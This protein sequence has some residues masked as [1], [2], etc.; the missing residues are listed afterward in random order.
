LHEVDRIDAHL[1]QAKA[2]NASGFLIT[3][4]RG[5]GKTSLLLHARAAAEGRVRVRDE[6]RRLNF[7]VLQTD[8]EPQTTQMAL[9][10]KIELALRRALIMNERAL[11]VLQRTWEFLQRLQAAGYGLKPKES[12]SLPDETLMEELAYSLASTTTAMTTPR[13][14]ADWGLVGVYDGVVLLVDEADSAS[15]QLE[16]GTFLKLLV[17]RVQRHGCERL[18]VGLAGTPR[19]REALLSSHESALRL[20]EVLEL[21]PL[22]RDETA[23]VLELGLAEANERNEEPMEIAP[24]AKDVICYLAEGLPH[25]IQQFAHSAFE[26]DED[27]VID[28]DDV[29]NAAIGEGGA[30]EALGN[31]MYRDVFYRRITD[32]SHRDVLRLAATHRGGWIGRDEL[33]PA[34]AGR[35]DQVDCALAALTELEVLVQDPTDASGYRLANRGLAMWIR[36]FGKDHETVKRES[37]AVTAEKSAPS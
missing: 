28:V 13:A 25:F 14:A 35:P 26:R 29:V 23:Q 11:G 18:L 6:R 24:E 5:I 8:I 1:L 20:F 32:E 34:L 31:R 27:G 17:E 2:G 30:I 9:A 19:V 15:P 36:L 21:G 37:L 33:A 4:E 12:S 3:G 10:R 7:L 16:L 22:T